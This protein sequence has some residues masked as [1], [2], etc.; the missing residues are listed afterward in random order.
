MPAGWSMPF[1]SSLT[2]TGTRVGGLREHHM[3]SFESGVPHFPEDYP[4]TAAYAR[5]TAIRAEEEKSR[6]ERKPP[7]KRPNFEKLGTRS[8]WEPDWEVV[9]GLEKAVEG[10]NAQVTCVT[11][12][13]EGPST[14]NVASGGAKLQPWLLRGSGVT[15][16]LEK[17]LDMFNPG[18]GLWHEMNVLRGKQ[19]NDPFSR[20]VKV[21]MLWKA[22][23]IM[24]KVVMCGRG[25]PDDLAVLYRL[26]DD[27]ARKL[28]SLYQRTQSLDGVDQALPDEMG[29]R[30]SPSL[31]AYSSW[32]I[33]RVQKVLDVRPSPDSI[34]GYVTT[35]SYSLSR[36]E[37]FC[38][39]VI[40]LAR[41]SELKEQAQR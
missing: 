6:W 14:F 4:C 8:P 32:L 21:E 31:S 11:T 28:R 38:I 40:P 34:I 10:Q 37:G 20:S 16:I 19:G 1:F 2:Y 27:E 29:V 15:K 7:A 18:A 41:L 35:G 26:E 17:S 5:H 24:V 12:Q 39:A 22:A 9:L 33:P 25:A 13:R 3:Q 36:G 23:L 30:D